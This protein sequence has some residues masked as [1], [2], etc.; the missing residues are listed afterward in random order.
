MNETTADYIRRHADDDIPTSKR[1]PQS[2]LDLLPV[3]FTLEDAIR[4]RQK[5]G[6]E[7]DERH[8]KKMIRNWANRNFVT[9]NSE[10]S[11]KKTSSLVKSKNKE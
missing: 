3:E 11:Y 9:Q 1:G 10:F 5:Q 6:L 4:V 8:T 7:G 2:L